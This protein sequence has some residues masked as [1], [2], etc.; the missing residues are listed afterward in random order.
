[1]YCA[2]FSCAATSIVL[3]LSFLRCIALSPLVCAISLRHLYTPRTAS[4]FGLHS[5]TCFVREAIATSPRSPT[6]SI[7]FLIASTERPHV[8]ETALIM[9]ESPMPSSMPS[10]A[11]ASL[12]V[13]TDMSGSRS[14]GDVAITV[15]KALAISSVMSSRLGS[16]SMRPKTRARKR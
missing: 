12:L 9:I 5:V 15:R 16:A 3:I 2:S 1:M 14:S 8:S 7:S 13:E 4:G 10:Y 6:S 11:G